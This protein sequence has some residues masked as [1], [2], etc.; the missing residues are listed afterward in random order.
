LREESSNILKIKVKQLDVVNVVKP[1]IKREPLRTAGRKPKPYATLIPFQIPGDAHA[2]GKSASW[3]NGRSGCGDTQARR[4][5]LC[6]TT[7]VGRCALP[8][9][10]RLP[11]GPAHHRR[12]PHLFGVY[13]CTYD[14][15]MSWSDTRVAADY[16]SGR[17]PHVRIAADYP[18]SG[19]VS[20]A[21]TRS[22]ACT[23]T[24]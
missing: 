21:N 3:P 13:V 14:A 10:I 7:S 5:G 15:T 23:M 4:T 19:A 12:L 17:L 6:V 8:P 9:P 1:D 24:T 20:C 11:P 16:P 22:Y 2:R 18:T